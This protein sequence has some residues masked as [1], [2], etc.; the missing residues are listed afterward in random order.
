M[1]Q[2]PLKALIIIV[3][4]C[5]VI[6]ILALI[7][8]FL[9]SFTVFSY[10]DDFLKQLGIDKP[11]ANEK[12]TSSILGG[13]LDVYGEKNAKNIAKGNRAAVANDLLTNTKKTC[14]Q[15]GIYPAI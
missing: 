11:A 7:S 4:L 8:L 15:R 9:F 5:T 3:R 1:K 10:G 14:Q 6:V 2:L 12:I 13:Y